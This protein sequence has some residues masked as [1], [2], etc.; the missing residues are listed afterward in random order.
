M[1]P[2]SEGGGKGL[3]RGECMTLC[4]VGGSPS[5]S[6]LELRSEGRDNDRRN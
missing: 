1:E 3:S 2:A 4:R 6:S 5:D